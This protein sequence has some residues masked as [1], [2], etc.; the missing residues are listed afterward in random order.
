VLAAGGWPALT[1]FT[2]PLLLLAMVL[3]AWHWRNRTLAS[4][5]GAPE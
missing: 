3:L 1:T 5:Q 4:R 2:S